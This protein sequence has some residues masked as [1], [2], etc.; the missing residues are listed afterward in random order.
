MSCQSCY[1]KDLLKSHQQDVVYCVQA[2]DDQRPVLKRFAR[3][4]DGS[5]RSRF[6]GFVILQSNEPKYA[7]PKVAEKIIT[8]GGEKVAL[9]VPEYLD[10]SH[11]LLDHIQRHV[12]Q[13]VNVSYCCCYDGT[14]TPC[15]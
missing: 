14:G 8:N 6:E 10:R 11:V 2:G 1:A 3:A 12:P 15:G 7:I 5:V 4:S 9:F 13:G